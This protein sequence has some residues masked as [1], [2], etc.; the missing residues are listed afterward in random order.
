MSDDKP[1]HGE[2]LVLAHRNLPPD[3]SRPT[4]L[5]KL[6]PDER[7][8]VDARG[9]MGAYNASKHTWPEMEPGDAYELGMEVERRPHV[10]AVLSACMVEDG[11]SAEALLRRGLA[12]MESVIHESE[13]SSEKKFGMWAE[14]TTKAGQCIQAG[15]HLRR[16]GGQPL[17]Q[18]H[19]KVPTQEDL[20]QL[21]AIQAGEYDPDDPSQYGVG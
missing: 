1:V 7:C 18:L 12:Q 13:L 15:I 11:T 14:L 5:A 2:V 16:D 10:A 20:D 9:T 17:R 4:A 6:S 8:Y 21:D 3:D 19:G